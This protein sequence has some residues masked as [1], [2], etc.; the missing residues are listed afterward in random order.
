[1]SIM[2]FDVGR[3]RVARGK[4]LGARCVGSAFAL[5]LGACSGSESDDSVIDEPAGD[6]PS[7]SMTPSM[8]ADDA[9]SSGSSSNTD[10][11]GPDV[12][13]LDEST[14]PDGD[15][16]TADEDNEAAGMSMDPTGAL[17]VPDTD[18]CAPVA[19]WDPAWVQFEEEVLL[20]VN[21]FRSQPADCG[22]EG[23][24]EAAA[25]LTM[26]PILR[27]SARL[28]SLDM[29]ERD[30]F[31][32]DTPDGVDPFERMAEA[33]FVGSGGGENIAFG[34]RS[35]QEVMDAWMESDG[36]CANVMRANFDTLGVGYHPGS[37]MRGGNSNYWTQNFGA[38]PFMRGGN[39]R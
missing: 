19:D 17:D 30:Y 35:P 1:M 21:E 12:T 13:D 38:P 37:Q 31:E 18:L 29:F 14:A 27:C 15:E 6:T 10:E 16:A 33:G 20:L 34:Q 5:L 36:H 26:N 28:H 2:R 7:T 8:P 24:F 39:R 9:M 3:G 4:W 22:V 11:D 23:E 25:P 32:H